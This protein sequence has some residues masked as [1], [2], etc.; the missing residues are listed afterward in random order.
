MAS[1]LFKVQGMSCQGCAASITRRLQ[2]TVGVTAAVVDLAGA[3]ATI[4]YDDA[5]VTPDSLEKVIEMLG[6]DVVHGMGSSK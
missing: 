3:T 1:V 2:A 4:D 6:F 5:V